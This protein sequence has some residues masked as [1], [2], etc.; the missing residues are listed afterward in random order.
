[1]LRYP[2]V[3]YV[4]ARARDHEMRARALEEQVA[5]QK[6]LLQALVDDRQRLLTRA[7]YLLAYAEGPRHVVEADARN[8]RGEAER[9][10]QEIE[11]RKEVIRALKDRASWYRRQATTEKGRIDD[12]MAQRIPDETGEM[13]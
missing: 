7:G 3:V 1:M 13:D 5:T 11:N 12:F 9:V 2:R 8:L 10:S 6:E 4:I